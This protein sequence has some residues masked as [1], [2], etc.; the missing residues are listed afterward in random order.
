MDVPDTLSARPRK[1]V[2]EFGE[3]MSELVA[4]HE[5]ISLSE[6]VKLLIEKTGLRTQYEKDLSDE[7]KTRLENMDE[8][9]GAVYEFEQAADEP[10]LSNYLE[11]VAL[12]TDLDQAEA[13]TKHVT[14]MSAF[15]QGT[16]I[17]YGLYG[18]SGRRH[19]PQ[20]SQHYG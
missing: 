12:I 19:F 10:T 9:L 2:R 16:G 4:Q 17:P 1:C 20:R 8:F 11:N 3:L 5:N 6:F 7:A 13:S 15:L 14:L 18:R